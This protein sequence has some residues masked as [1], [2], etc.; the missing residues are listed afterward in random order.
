MRLCACVLS[1]GWLFVTPGP[2]ALQAPLSMGFPRQE[3]WSGFLSPSPG[4]LPNPG[5]EPTSPVSPELAGGCFT[6]SH[7]GS[8]YMRLDRAKGGGGGERRG[9]RI[10]LIHE[11]SINPH[12][13]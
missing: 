9:R 5:T 1:R 3:F 10:I 2:V 4:D 6:L 7:L 13:S 11:S 12:N 8:R